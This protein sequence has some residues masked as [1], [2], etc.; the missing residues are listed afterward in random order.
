MRKTLLFVRAPLAVVTL[1]AGM[2]WAI[3]CTNNGLP[4]ILWFNVAIVGI[5]IAGIAAAW[6]LIGD[7]WDSQP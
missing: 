1:L 5:A 4:S 7:Y 3:W 6:L 2:D